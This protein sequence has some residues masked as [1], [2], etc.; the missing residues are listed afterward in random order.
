M[1]Y[2][3]HRSQYVFQKQ[4]TYIHRF[5][6]LVPK[7]LFSLFEP[8][9]AAYINWKHPESKLIIPFNLVHYFVASLAILCYSLLQVHVVMMCLQ[10][11][12][13]SC[14]FSCLVE[15]HKII[16]NLLVYGFYCKHFH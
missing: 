10:R 6:K 14:S 3:S 5:Y 9:R 15:R 12:K 7:R 2:F 16:M 1:C 8:Q 11:E 13:C 4:N